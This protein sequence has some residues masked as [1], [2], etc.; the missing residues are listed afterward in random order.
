M[1]W[2]DDDTADL[3]VGILAA[4]S[5][6]LADLEIVLVPPWNA[7]MIFKVTTSSESCRQRW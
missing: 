3:G 6:D 5:Y 1:V 2:S 4:S 7:R